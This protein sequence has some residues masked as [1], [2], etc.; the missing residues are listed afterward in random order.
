MKKGIY[1]VVIVT[2]TGYTSSCWVVWQ[3]IIAASFRPVLIIIVRAFVD[4]VDIVIVG[5]LGFVVADSIAIGIV[6]GL[7]YFIAFVTA[8]VKLF[9]PTSTSCDLCL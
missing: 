7:A 1:V 5:I 3:R 8:S 9:P 2:T 6:A 4:I